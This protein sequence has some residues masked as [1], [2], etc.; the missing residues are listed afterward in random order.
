VQLNTSV[1]RRIHLL[2]AHATAT[3]VQSYHAL[4][5][6]AKCCGVGLQG[7]KRDLGQAFK[8]SDENT[9]ERWAEWSLANLV[10]ELTKCMPLQS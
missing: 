7:R 3:R 2:C 4:P 10:S 9:L 5:P 6:L 1:G 8:A